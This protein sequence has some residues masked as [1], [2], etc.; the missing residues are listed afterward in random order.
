MMIMMMQM[1]SM[2]F[3]GMHLQ[4]IVLQY[5]QNIVLPYGEK[6]LSLETSLNSWC[7]N[8]INGYNKTVADKKLRGVMAISEGKAPLSF[9]G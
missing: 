3:E 6:G 9:S 7:D 8:F 2:A 5:L 1:P 4:I